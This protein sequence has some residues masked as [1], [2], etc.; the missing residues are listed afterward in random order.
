MNSLKKIDLGV[1]VDPIVDRPIFICENG[2][3]FH[4]EYTLIACADCVLSKTKGNTVS[5]LSSYST[6]ILMKS[7]I[8]KR[9]QQGK[10]IKNNQFV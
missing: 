3:M 8:I 7:I 9:V 5:Y 1:V 10:R 6:K 2:S 4:Q